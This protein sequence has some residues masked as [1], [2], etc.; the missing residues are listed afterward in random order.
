M[1][2]F[3]K[4]E[5]HCHNIFSNHQNSSVRLPYD[6]GVVIE[7]QLHRA[8]ER[9]IDV[10]FVTNHNTL[11]GYK[12]LLEYKNSHA[13]FDWI[14][15]YP[16]EEVTIDTQGHILAYGLHQRIRP[17]M[18]LEETLEE[19]RS[20]N[21]ISCAAHPFA[22][23]NGIR[24]KALLCD[25][26]ESFNSN[27][28]DRFSNVIAERF[29]REHEMR[30]IAGSDSHVLSTIGKCVNIIE[31]ENNLGS[32]L[33][34][35][36]KGKLEIQSKDYATNEQ[37]FDHAYYIISSSRELLLQYALR[38]HPQA[39][40]AAKW[41][42]NSFTSDPNSRMWRSLAKFVLYLAKR[43]SEKVNVKGYD[44]QIFVERPWKKLIAISLTP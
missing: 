41:A 4:A 43:A 1:T 5:L 6:C 28:V 14:S 8:F 2:D 27:N 31:S 16:A 3:L 36:R 38:H 17:G 37:I 10:L 35:M 15:I 22:I 24:E 33:D 44:P 34:A 40:T 7:D 23:T 20:Q 25:M 42:L 32:I 9:G 26:I 12:Q 30:V 21:A 11:D 29:A 18:A 19:I 39:Y 13:K